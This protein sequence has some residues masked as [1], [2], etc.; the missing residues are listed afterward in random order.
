MENSVNIFLP[1]LD[2]QI[3][4]VRREL[5]LEGKSSLTIGAASEGVVKVFAEETKKLAELIV[6]DYS[7]LMNSRPLLLGAWAWSSVL[8]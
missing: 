2:N 4:F 8:D 1:G 3:R 5:V 7:S 6:E